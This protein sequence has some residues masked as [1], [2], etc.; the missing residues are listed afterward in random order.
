MSLYYADHV[1]HAE[2]EARGK[3][4]KMTELKAM[5]QPQVCGA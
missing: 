2:Q 5:N 4:T 1:A 3:A